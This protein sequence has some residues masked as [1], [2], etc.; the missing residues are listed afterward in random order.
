MKE[1]LESMYLSWNNDLTFSIFSIFLRNFLSVCN[2]VKSK[3][4]RNY[5]KADVVSN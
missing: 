3:K 4:T 5:L 1:S 2:E